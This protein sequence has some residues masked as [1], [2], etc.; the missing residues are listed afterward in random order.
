MV[1][2]DNSNE[3]I[4]GI[5]E[6]LTRTHEE[7]MDC[8]EVYE[9]IDQFVDAKVRGED[10]S[11]VMPLVLRHLQLCRDCLEEYEALLRVIA[12]EEGLE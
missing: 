6:T 12:A 11:E 10:V 2:M 9:V 1:K 3:L 7:E 5:L 4:K 8:D